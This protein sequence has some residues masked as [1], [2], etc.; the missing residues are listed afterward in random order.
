MNKLNFGLGVTDTFF[1]LLGDGA[2][3]LQ[4]QYT[5]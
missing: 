5:L 4:L 3:D 2:T 1:F